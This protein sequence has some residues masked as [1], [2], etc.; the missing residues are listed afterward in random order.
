MTWQD[1]GVTL[2]VIGAVIYLARKFFGRPPRARKTTF[3]SVQD[4]K[5]RRR[6]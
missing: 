5:S 6:P 4:L 3:I 2:V 1:A